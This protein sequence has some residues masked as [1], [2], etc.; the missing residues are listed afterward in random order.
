MTYIYLPMLNRVFSCVTQKIDREL[1]VEI[2]KKIQ[3]GF[4]IHNKCR[5]VKH[6]NQ[7]KQLTL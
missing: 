7:L 3:N 5:N 1:I 2:K 6:T 4:L